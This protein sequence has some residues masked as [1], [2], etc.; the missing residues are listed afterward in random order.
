MKKTHSY[1]KNIRREIFGSFGR[2]FSIFAI[3][4]LGTG[5]FAGLTA[6]SPDMLDSVDAY[7][8][9]NKIADIE[10]I[11]SLGLTHADADALRGMDGISQVSPIYRTDALVDYAGDQVLAARLAT[12]FVTFAFFEQSS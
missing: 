12:R 6:T 4:A 10:V 5:F 2:F 1:A 7:Y 8:D 11:S 9:E 3:V